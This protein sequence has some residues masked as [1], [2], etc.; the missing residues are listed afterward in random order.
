MFYSCKKN[1][2][3]IKII[4]VQSENFPSFYNSFYK[5]K[6][7]FSSGSVAEGIAVKKI[8]TINSKILNKNVDK[9]ILVKEKK[10]EEAIS[11][12]LMKD[13]T[14]VEGAGAVGLAAILEDKNTQIFK[15]YRNSCLWRKP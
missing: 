8:G 3:N 14:L 10:I 15:K 7:S 1:K 6:Y 12:F 9:C 5:K 4:A 2:K 11:H 13:K